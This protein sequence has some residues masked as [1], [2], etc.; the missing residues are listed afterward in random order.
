MLKDKPDIIKEN[1]FIDKLYATMN[2]TK[3]TYKFVQITD[4]HADFWYQQ[5]ASADC[6]DKYCCRNDSIAVQEGSNKIAGKYGAY[7]SAKCDIPLVTVRETLEFIRDQIKPDAIFWTGDNSP[8][9]GAKGDK[10]IYETAFSTNITARMIQEI[11]QDQTNNTYAI[12]GN[13]DI[14][15]HWD[16]NK[17]DLGNPAVR[18]SSY[19]WR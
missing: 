9:D 8:H 3:N 12:L 5:G 4:F 13:H 7:P 18:Q 10:G 2:K 11:L 17:N 16:F 15:P 6:Q 14:Y 1:N 19:Y